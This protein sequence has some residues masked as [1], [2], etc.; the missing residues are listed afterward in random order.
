MIDEQLTLITKH[1]DDL[2]QAYNHV[3]K[4]EQ[5]RCREVVELQD[6]LSTL[7][8]QLQEATDANCTFEYDEDGT[9]YTII[10]GRIQGKHVSKV[11]LLA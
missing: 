11:R 1:R 4:C 3:L 7:W 10:L 2:Q 6:Q 9:P 5:N 8:I